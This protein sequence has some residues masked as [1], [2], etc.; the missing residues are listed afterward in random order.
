MMVQLSKVTPD[1]NAR[2]YIFKWP[3]EGA[4]TLLLEAENE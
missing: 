3:L 4:L 2:R 1:D